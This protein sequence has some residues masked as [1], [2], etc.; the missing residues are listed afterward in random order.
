MPLWLCCVT[1]LV[2]HGAAILLVLDGAATLD[3]SSANPMST[4]IPLCLKAHHF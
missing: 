4:L 1:R 2:L 3:K